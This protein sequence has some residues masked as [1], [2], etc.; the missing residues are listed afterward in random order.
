MSNFDYIQISNRLASSTTHPQHEDPRHL[1]YK[2]VCANI[3]YIL[4]ADLAAVWCIALPRATTHEPLRPRP[5][6]ACQVCS[7]SDSDDQLQSPST[8]RTCVLC[9]RCLQER[10]DISTQGTCMQASGCPGL[11]ATYSLEEPSLVSRTLRIYHT[12]LDPT[13]N[14][15]ALSQ[16]RM[17][18]R[19]G[20]VGGDRDGDR[21]EKGPSS[22]MADQF[23]L[24]H[25]RPPDTCMVTPVLLQGHVPRDTALR[26]QS[27]SARLS[28]RSG[29]VRREPHFLERY[30]QR[31]QNTKSGHVCSMLLLQGTVRDYI[32]SVQRAIDHSCAIPSFNTVVKIDLVASDRSRS[33][34][35]KLRTFPYS[36]QP[37][38]R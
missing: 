3:H 31:Q 8:P 35:S 38:L 18:P 27:D 28:A 6:G 24:H 12:Y 15:I 7:T 32:C 37:S 5:L 33:V 13:C 22:I 10:V 19:G 20:G 17:M 25:P 16:H 26:V 29:G 4:A 11:G 30:P 23:A 2:R 1:T 9:Q 14:A 21:A 34:C 36:P